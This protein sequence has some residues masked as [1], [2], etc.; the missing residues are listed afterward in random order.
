MNS[1]QVIDLMQRKQKTY[2]N[3]LFERPESL[4]KLLPY[5]EYLKE[6]GVFVNKDGSLGAAFQIELTEH[7]ALDKDAIVELVGRF[8]H[9]LSLPSNCVLQVIFEQEPI[10]PSDHTVNA[11]SSA[12]PKSHAVSDL[13]FKEKLDRIVGRNGENLALKRKCMIT[14]RYFPKESSRK[15]QNYRLGAPDSG[16]LHHVMSQFV[17]EFNHFNHILNNIRLHCPLKLTQI[18]ADEMSAHLRKF[19]NPKQWNK[20]SFSKHNPDRSFSDQVIYSKPKLNYS[21]I[22]REGIRTRTISLKHAPPLA[23]PGQMSHF[24]KLKFPYRLCINFSFP[25]KGKT[26]FKLDLK[27]FFLQNTPSASSQRQREELLNVQRSLSHGDR[28]THMTLTVVVEGENEEELDEKSR[29]VIRVMN[30]DLSCEA[31]IEEDIG[32]AQCLNSLPLHYSAVADHSSQRYTPILISDAVRFLPIFDSFRGI[33][34]PSKAHSVYRSREGNLVP[35]S[36]LNNETS[37]HTVVAGKTGS[38]KSKVVLD[39]AYDLKRLHPEP[40]IFIIDYKTSG[41]M[42]CE[43]YDGVLNQYERNQ[44]LQSGPFSG[45]FDEDKVAFLSSLFMTAIRMTSPTFIEEGE[46]RAILSRAIKNAHERKSKELGLHYV[47]GK[48]VQQEDS[49]QVDI[50]MEDV[51]AELSALTGVAAYENLQSHIETL[52]DKLRPLY[53]DGQYAH[54]FNALKSKSRSKSRFL[55]FDLS[56]L[57]HDSVLQSLMTMVIFEEIR[58]VMKLPENE[59]RMGFVI[60]EEL[61]RLAKGN[62]TAKDYI[63][64]LAETGRKSNFWLISVAPTPEVYFD[65]ESGIGPALWE[66]ADNFLFLEMGPDSANCLKENLN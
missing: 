23:Y 19:F 45:V 13:L 1:E 29:E 54:Y 8:Q 28:V 26:K 57:S 22:E 18:G 56:A 2:A 36:I 58:Q 63:R 48:F 39:I 34:D 15:Y 33:D 3:A 14:V 52:A 62:P 7:E 12:Y 43:L 46:H 20:R 59:G 21:G 64:V 51:I 35:F 42:A 31:I 4:S 6:Y 40:I 49:P 5:H 41:R 16:I 60:F 55:V 27:E 17:T 25:E 30:Q 37:H 32:L 66:A 53:G 47:A 50:G 11:L 44:T 61:Q 24:T 9:I 65:E 38:G 10:N